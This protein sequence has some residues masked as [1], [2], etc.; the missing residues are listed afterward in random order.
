MKANEQASGVTREVHTLWNLVL[1]RRM[2][3]ALSEG[4]SRY[5]IYRVLH[6]AARIELDVLARR[7]SAPMRGASARS[8]RC[9]A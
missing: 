2:A 7:R 3:C 6:F 1:D 4:A 8:R 9:T 5:P